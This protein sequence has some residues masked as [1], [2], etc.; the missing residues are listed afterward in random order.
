[1]KSPRDPSA[2]DIKSTKLVS[3]KDTIPNNVL[4][5]VNLL[6]TVGVTELKHQ[7]T[8]IM[9]MNMNNLTKNILDQKNTLLCVPIAMATLIKYAMKNDLA[10]D[11]K[12]GDFTMEKICISLTMTVYPRSLA[13][14]NLNPNDDEIKSQDNDILSLLNRMTKRTYLN[15]SGWEMIRSNG[16]RS[17][18]S[19]IC[20]FNLCRTTFF[21]KN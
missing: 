13:G 21:E 14:L 7:L 16:H 15:E 2:D 10:F 18:N 9:N 3:L 8:K 11:D 4:T 19:S 6:K 1:M 12:L 5:D 20:K 17:P